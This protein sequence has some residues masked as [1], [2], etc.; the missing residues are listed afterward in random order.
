[1][2]LPNIIQIANSRKSEFKDKDNLKE[3]CDCVLKFNKMSTNE[4]ILFAPVVKRYKLQFWGFKNRDS[5]YSCDLMVGNRAFQ[6]IYEIYVFGA[7]RIIYAIDI[8]IIVYFDKKH[9]EQNIHEFNTLENALSFVADF[10]N[11]LFEK[12][13]AGKLEKLLQKIIP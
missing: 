4:L 1:M 10:N 11:Q 2:K 6:D 3:L 7:C 12:S 5:F 13:I 9:N 8:K